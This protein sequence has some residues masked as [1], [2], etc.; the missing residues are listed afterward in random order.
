M[1]EGGGSMAGT[2]RVLVLAS[3]A[4]FPH[5]FPG[6]VRARLD[7]VAEWTRYES[8]EDSPGLREAIAS[9]DALVTT[10]H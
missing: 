3:D 1:N 4:L 8:R 2:P 9:S 6:A 7:E 10:W 5:F